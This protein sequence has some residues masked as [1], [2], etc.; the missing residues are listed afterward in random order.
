[1]KTIIAGGRDYFLTEFDESRL[2]GLDITEVVCGCARG[3]DTGGEMWAQKRGIPVKRFPADWDGLGKGAGPVR[4]CQMAEYVEALVAFP[5]GRRPP[6]ACCFAAVFPFAGVGL[7]G[8]V[9]SRY[10]RWLVISSLGRRGIGFWYWRFS[11]SQST[12]GFHRGSETR[13]PTSD[14]DKLFHADSSS[15]TRSP[16]ATPTALLLGF[17]L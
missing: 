8:M 10:F 9:L 16:H 11:L 12:A 1:M 3:A 2:D 13:M 15:P 5:G 17:G 6:E 14:A 7:V 4:N